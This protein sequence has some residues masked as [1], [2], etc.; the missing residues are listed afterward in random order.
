MRAFIW[1]SEGI[2]DTGKHFVIQE[3]IREEKLDIV[4]ILETGR[5]NFSASFLRNL[6]AR[7]DFIWFCLPSR[8]RS[9]GILV[10][11]NAETLMV[12][13]VDYGDFL[14]RLNLKSKKD[15]FL[16]SFVT[17]YGAAQEEHKPDFLAELV[18]LCD[19]PGIPMIIGGDFNILRNPFEKSNGN[20]NP[21]WPFMFNA[22]IGSLNLRELALSGR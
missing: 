22:I 6:S 5:S 19:T 10:G 9:G 1:N 17:V 2:R 21:K 11:I 3:A 18:R 8:G 4:A 16:W 15:G 12:K 7:K 13:D 20:Y 14:V